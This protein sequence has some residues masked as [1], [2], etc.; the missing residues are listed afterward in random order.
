[1]EAPG[2]GIGGL[3]PQFSCENT[4]LRRQKKTTSGKN[5]TLNRP[6]GDLKAQSFDANR[7]DAGLAMGCIYI[8]YINGL[9]IYKNHLSA[10]D[11]SALSLSRSLQFSFSFQPFG[12]SPHL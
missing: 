2:Y 11:I 4:G 10:S 3:V 5:S 12:H 7:H 9:D 6:K 1:M 8:E